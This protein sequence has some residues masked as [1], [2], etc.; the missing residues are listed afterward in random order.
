[1]QAELESASVP[2]GGKSWSSP[3]VASEILVTEDQLVRP[4]SQ[5]TPIRESGEGSEY[6]VGNL[7]AS[8]EALGNLLTGR[9]KEEKEPSQQS[10]AKRKVNISVESE[11]EEVSERQQSDSK[12]QKAPTI[13]IPSENA[14]LTTGI[15]SEEISA[16][17]GSEPEV[18]SLVKSAASSLENI[19]KIAGLGTDDLRIIIAKIEQKLADIERQTGVINPLMPLVSEMLGLDLTLSREESIRVIVPIIDKVI[20]ETMIER[21]KT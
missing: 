16:S 18:E 11:I 3:E 13:S 1:M 10:A 5:T 12:V 19:E 7:A 9:P 4:Y 2:H 17:Q 15:S 20:E 8:L 21:G 14:A 6:D